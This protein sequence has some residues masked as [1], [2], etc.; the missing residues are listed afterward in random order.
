MLKFAEDL[1]RLIVETIEVKRRP[2]NT[3]QDVLSIMVRASAGAEPAFSES[4]LP[5]HTV[6]MFGASFET[7]ADAMGWTLFLLAQHP[8]VASSL[9]DELD[10]ARFSDPPTL[11]ELDRLTLLNAVIDEAMRLLPPVPYTI[12]TVTSAVDFDG[13]RLTR[14]DRIVISHYMTHHMPEIYP[15]PNRFAPERW[16]SFKADPYVYLPFSAGPRLCVGYHFAMAE[17]R[18][19]LLRIMKR[20]RLTVVPGSRI[21]RTVRVT[22]NPTFGLPMI[23]YPQ[24]RKFA[25]SAVTGQ[26]HEMVDL[27]APM[28]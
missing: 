10:S 20:Y 16:F 21:D 2:G 7:A 26:I 24:D 8:K 4:E 5:G 13:L 23:V 25:A 17:I 6:F 27:P 9:L 22:L 3:S 1:E 18:L 12:R 14:G 19:A 28:I 15:M 11:D